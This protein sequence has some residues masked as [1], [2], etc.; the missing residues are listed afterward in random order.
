MRP[1]PRLRPPPPCGPPVRPSAPP[2]GTPRLP[3]RRT[4]ALL[5]CAVAAAALL[6]AGCRDETPVRIGVAVGPDAEQGARA[7]AETVNA[8]GGIGGRPLELVIQSGPNT[9]AVPA[10]ES[11]ERFA[12][13]ETI[14]AVVGHRNS[15]ASLVA[16]QVYNARG[17]VQISPTS[18]APMLSVAG[19][20]TFRLVPS[21][22]AQAPFLARQARAL[23]GAR[24]AAILYENDD[25][26]RALHLEL[27]RELEARGVAVV[28][29]VPYMRATGVEA[30][31]FVPRSLATHPPEVVFW[32]GRHYRLR[33]FMAALRAVA[34]G[35]LVLGSD[36]A[37]SPE[38][39]RA[40][41]EFA[42]LHF[43]RFV[44][45][46]SK[47]P[48]MARFRKRPQAR[49]GGRAEDVLAHDA[50]MA[51]VEVMRAG[52]TT[53]TAVRDRL[54]AMG[55]T[56]PAGRGCGGPIRFDR[57]GDVERPYLLARVDALGVHAIEGDR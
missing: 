30:M 42:G 44:D 20:F 40:P 54:A 33:E 45:P 28:A 37:D 52:A 24:S 17:L 25:Y 3:L 48:C 32:L 18:T 11:A 7:A 16:S 22:L 35:V 57:V 1:S 34:P 36:A 51:L 23:A 31:E 53:R 27:S 41:A 50:V 49:Y 5:A 43:V 14:L 10:M 29:S 19:P 56:A 39:Y 2:A 4:G 47:E 26:G 46:A 9:E 8:T 12:A 21:D 15:A 38:V 13:D 6:A 55:T